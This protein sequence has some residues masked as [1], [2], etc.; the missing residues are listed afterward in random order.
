MQCQY[1]GSEVPDDVK[2]CLACGKLL[3]EENDNKDESEEDQS[4]VPEESS[5]DDSRDSQ[6]SGDDFSGLDKLV[7][8]EEDDESG[9]EQDT[10]G[11]EGGIPQ[12]QNPKKRMHRGWIAAIIVAVVAVVVVAIV[13]FL[14]VSSG[15]EIQRLFGLGG[16][17][18]SGLLAESETDDSDTE[19]S[20]LNPDAE[21]VYGSSDEFSIASDTLIFPQDAQGNTLSSYSVRIM[22]RTLP[23]NSAD[24]K[25]F[26]AEMDGAAGFSFTM[27]DQSIPTG[28]YSV[29]INTAEGESY[30]LP[31]LN[32]SSDADS[33]DTA[34][35][36]TVS[37]LSVRPPT[38]DD[39]DASKTV[40]A[41][42]LYY[43]KCVEYEET[44]GHRSTLLGYPDDPTQNLSGSEV[45]HLEGF[46]SVYVEDFTNDG[47]DNLV[48]VYYSPDV[49]IDENIRN[50]NVSENFYSHYIVEVWEYDA[51]SIDMVYQGIPLIGSNGE[52]FTLTI[53]SWD[54][55]T[56]LMSGEIGGA[57]VFGL[58]YGYTEDGFALAHVID[59]NLQNGQDL[60]TVD[61]QTVDGWTYVNEHMTYIL[62]DGLIYTTDDSAARFYQTVRNIRRIAGVIPT[63]NFE[64]SADNSSDSLE[65][66]VIDSPS[67]SVLENPSEET[68]PENSAENV[69]EGGEEGEE[70][71]GDTNSD[72][73]LPDEST[74]YYDKS[75]LETL[76]D[77]DLYLARNEIYARYGR[78]FSSSELQDY[79]N[80]KEWYTQSYS[81]EE[82]D[83]MESPLNQ[84]EK[85]NADLIREV[86]REKGSPYL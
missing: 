51:G 32:Y 49:L 10:P 58:L 84:Y 71:S 6:E 68:I 23:Y 22:P 40:Q 42:T 2:F 12:D 80:S 14:L 62:E 64:E 54:G 20:V 9:S 17:N 67:D 19:N 31:I 25:H 82:F 86:E 65:I 50:R 45:T 34:S 36:D 11:Q 7:H 16:S 37:Q 24:Q 28:S 1:C 66:E 30:V 3:K 27:V 69:E 5:N 21:A 61:G 83:A 26:I 43:A 75:E 76:S 70:A 15:D 38:I 56:C 72:Y 52:Q 77:Y 44:Y 33:E 29:G 59:I 46:C 8:T 55:Q 41:Y 13:V 79:F 63:G 48:C 85:A 53:V 47:L 74:R 18:E 73:I 57:F 35:E 39:R 81:P 78:G 4:D 60:N